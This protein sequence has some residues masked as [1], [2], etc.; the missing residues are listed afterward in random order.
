MTMLC[1]DLGERYRLAQDK[2]FR[3]LDNLVSGLQAI[4][5][6]ELRSETADLT[7]EVPLREVLDNLRIVVEPAWREIEGPF[8]GIY[9][10]TYPS[11]A[12]NRTACCRRF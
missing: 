4:A 1:E 2:S 5:A 7:E 8:A 3:G 11:F 10:M 12:R 9:L 6:H